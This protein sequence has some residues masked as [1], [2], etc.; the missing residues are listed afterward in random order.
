[1]RLREKRW[2]IWRI[3]AEMTLHD[4]AMTK[5]SQWW[6]RTFRSGHAYAEGYAL[7]GAPPEC[8]NAKQVR[9]IWIW[10]AVVPIGCV[11]ASVIIAFIAP[12][13]CWVPLLGFLLYPLLMFKVA[14]SKRSMAYGFF[15]VLGKFPQML[16]M[17]KYKRSRARGTRSTLIEYKGAAVAPTK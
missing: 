9:S 10:G 2:E 3:D 15:V 17:L 12:R 7:H 14:R 11:I 8:H 1:V 6:N 13:W 16:G 4:A 5:F